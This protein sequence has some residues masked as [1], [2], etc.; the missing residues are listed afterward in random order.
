[1]APAIAKTTSTAAEIPTM[2]LILLFSSVFT[3]SSERPPFVG[4][5]DVRG[6][7]KDGLKFLLAFLMP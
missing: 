3:G 5:E 4:A 6:T 1:M 7:A 2:Y